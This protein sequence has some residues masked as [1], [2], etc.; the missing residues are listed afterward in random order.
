[1]EQQQ[2]VFISPSVI[3][4]LKSG[5]F[6]PE[7]RSQGSTQTKDRRNLISP[8][9]I[10]KRCVRYE[11]QV[12]HHRKNL[13]LDLALQ[14]NEPRHKIF[15]VEGGQGSGKTSLIRGLIEMMGT[16]LPETSTQ[17]EPQLLWFDVTR[18]TDF[19]EIIQFLIQYISDVCIAADGSNSQGFK[20][21]PS[22]PNKMR[23]EQPIKRLET[24]IGRVRDLPLLIVLDNVEYIVNAELRFN[25]Y[26]FKEM[27][28]F[29]LTFPN[30]KMV[31]I[32][33]R[34]PYADM[35]PNQGGVSNL[36]L[37]G[38][39]EADAL[40]FLEKKK[41]SRV[42]SDPAVLELSAAP[43]TLEE[44]AARHLY[45]K[46]QGAPWLMKVFLY[47][48]DQA[49]LDF[50]A[51]NRLLD[52]E[53]DDVKMDGF[54]VEALIRLVYERLNESQRKL[55]QVLA[56]VRHPLSAKTLQALVGVCYPVLS[57]GGGELDN[58]ADMLEH[59]LLRPLLKISY[60]PQEVLAHVRQRTG[61]GSDKNERKYKPW[62][63]LYH[64]VRRTLAEGIAPEERERLHHILQDFY[65][66]E[67]AQEREQRI[68]A[69]KGRALLAEA[70]YHG[71]VSR[72]RKPAGASSPGT[73]EEWEKHAVYRQS[74]PLVSKEQFTLEEY[75]RLD[76]PSSAVLGDAAESTLA[77]PTFLELMNRNEKGAFQEMLSELALTEEEQHLLNADKVSANPFAA[78]NVLDI[79]R[80]KETTPE[81]VSE[82]PAS[83][84]A[85]DKAGSVPDYENFSEALL[86]T[87]HADEEERVIQQ[88]LAAAVAGQD[89]ALMVKELL[90]LARYRATRGQYCNAGPCL[91]KA[92]SLKEGI[93]KETMAEVYQLSG[94]V[95]KET[96]HHNAAMA[97]LTKAAAVIRRLMYEDD[98]VGPVWL[99]RLGR[100]FQ[101]MGEIHAYRRHAEEAIDAFNQALRW[102]H[103]SDNNARQAE[104]YFQLAGVYDS[105]QER[106]NA[107][108]YY[109][110][111]LELDERLGN[112]ISAAA[113]LANLGA[114]YTEM[115]QAAEAL[116]CL[117]R[118]LAYDRETGN[119]EG[120]LNTLEMM[121]DL[122]LARQDWSTGETLARQG[123][124][125]ALQEGAA[126]WKAT[127]Y[128]KLGELSAA[129][130]HWPQALKHY[131]AARTAGEKEL[132]KDSLRW[133]EQ[134]I[135]ELRNR[136]S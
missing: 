37:P 96:F 20:I 121:V 13:I 89:K 77:G 88:R 22:L 92:L 64:V 35:S 58:P 55:F 69:L 40:A 56:L 122:C 97:S 101:D 51:L 79:S 94:T 6:V 62:Y 76:L 47:L 116:T 74:Q 10:T 112:K 106:D 2:P 7:R 65:I 91:E 120:Q 48:N 39:E 110:K 98:T 90:A 33:E 136:V 11:P 117:Q 130:L 125:M 17:R 123:L 34:L 66:R 131:E 111:A 26:P 30:I 31:L 60:P 100:V 59:S 81:S 82:P 86:V 78:S 49:K 67:R 135:A 73:G 36:R 46:A 27:L 102:Y 3:E 29:L 128:L 25:S 72:V 124:A 53:T 50:Y 80:A 126:V 4:R 52:T 68:L 14:F 42:D 24:L 87:A 95:N 99:E 108:T 132:A 109:R 15:L 118:A 61:I 32:G 45:V 113:A 115:G 44:N 41:T 85:N 16:R 119:L 1:M 104:V 84:P 12:F 19:E 21:E 133:I 43:S 103:S 75:Q 18:H 83:Q 57:A 23:T 70:K 107:V 63:E 134:K 5:A 93:G 38:L 8:L 54:P 9:A 71:G 114:L 28:N 129:F 105:R 127:F